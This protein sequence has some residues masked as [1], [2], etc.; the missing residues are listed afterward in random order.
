MCARI[1]MK[2]ILIPILAMSSV[3]AHQLPHQSGDGGSRVCGS[4]AGPIHLEAATIFDYWNLYDGANKNLVDV[5]TLPENVEM[6][7]ELLREECSIYAIPATHELAKTCGEVDHFL[8]AAQ[9]AVQYCDENHGGFPFFTGPASFVQATEQSTLGVH[10]DE[11]HENEG[12]TFMCLSD[13][14]ST[15]DE[16]N[17]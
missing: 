6:E 13:C 5:S 4:S 1:M 14:Y 8:M 11:Y 12:V 17:F 2:K 9:A 7:D 16:E 10:H 3:Q 15:S